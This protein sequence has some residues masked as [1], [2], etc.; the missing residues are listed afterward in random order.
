VSNP[1][2]S[3]II[4]TY[5]RP[6]ELDEALRSVLRQDGV[7]LELIVVDDSAEGSAESV[8]NALGDPRIS[9]VR[10]RP[11]SGGR[12]AGPRNLG[13]S[14]ASGELVHFMDDDDHV[15]AGHY[16]E[17]AAFFRA[18]PNVDVLFGRVLPF[19]A[20]EAQVAAEAAYFADAARRARRCGRLG[21]IA[22]RWAFAAS[23]LFRPAML[24]CGAAILRRSCIAAIDGFDLGLP[25]VE[26]VD[27]YARAVRRFDVRFVDR[28]TLHYRIAPS[29]MH[30]PG[31]RDAIVASY[32]LM[33]ARYRKEHG[34]ADFFL[35][36]TFAKTWGA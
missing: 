30:G 12:P 5:R 6:A 17:A 26:D 20:D 31:R 25:L 4:P 9:Y 15:P 7:T 29:M 32:R 14:L 16:A 34:V 35:L 28:P 33:H 13:A 2:I 10:N 24:V 22:G 21:R 23:M 36:K 1:D 11:P 27:F 3:V 18:S 8:V 19:G